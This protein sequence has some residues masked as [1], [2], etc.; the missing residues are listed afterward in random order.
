MDG[1]GFADLL[2]GAPSAD[3]GG[4]ASG[5]TYLISGQHLAALDAADVAGID[6]RIDL[7]D[8]DVV[9]ATAADGSVIAYQFIGIDGSDEAGF[10]VSSAGDV[11]GD[12][13]AD[14]L[15]GT[16]AESIVGGVSESSGESYLISGQHLAALDA[17]DDDGADGRIDLEVVV[18]ATAADGSVIAYQ[19]TGDNE[20]G[21]SVSTAGNVDGLGGDDLLIGN[22]ANAGNATSGEAYLITEADLVDADG[23]ND[24]VIDL[25]TV[26]FADLT[27]SYHFF[28]GAAGA[29][30]GF[31]VSSAGDVDGDGRADILIGAPE[32]DGGGEN[33]GET[34]L[35][36]A[37]DL[38]AA[39]SAD[40]EDGRI[41]LENF[42]PGNITGL[43][44]SYRF[45]GID[46]RDLAGFSV[47][48]AGD[49]DGDGRADLLIGARDAGE[50]EDFDDEGT[51]FFG[52]GQTYLITAAG[53]EALD[54]ADGT[55]DQTIDLGTTAPY[56]INVEVDDQ[57]DGTVVKDGVGTD[58]VES[59][60]SFVAGEAVDEIDEIT[61]TPNHRSWFHHRPDRWYRYRR[62]R[63][64]N[65]GHFYTI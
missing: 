30:A 35:I 41:D 7:G 45:I 19:F 31:S 32:A 17:A 10:S 12:G 43:T 55:I 57:G 21:V 15:I 6:G 47:S 51:A 46:E 64:P 60:E 23:D 14:L 48:S 2:I 42:N 62:G 36:T 13:F 65:S 63:W 37:A 34:Y 18:G 50:E 26:N 16:D 20:A 58:A 39:D 59:V 9:G 24:G 49:V 54:A 29:E 38:A 5:E 22:F 28:G 25:E 56:T 40:G 53:L 4:N 8:E 44:S 61:I 27:S 33:S 3:G 11:D 52:A 1:D